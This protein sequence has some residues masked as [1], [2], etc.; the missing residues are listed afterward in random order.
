M[1]RFLTGLAGLALMA[2]P[3]APAVY[4]AAEVGKPAPDF[5]LEASDGKAHRL[6][7]HLGEFVVLEWY[8]KSCPFVKKH[9]GSGNMQKLQ[10]T[11]LHKGVTWFSIISSAPGKE[12]YLTRREAVKNRIDSKIRST[13]TLFDPEGVAGRAYGAEVTPH[14]FIIDPKGAVI[15]AGAIDSHNSP[16]PA[17]IPSST[18]YVAQAL[19]QALA[20]RPVTTP[21]TT[22]YGCSIKY[23]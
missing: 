13:A 18:N 19:D 23:K 15:Y 5:S 17:D 1:K 8:N 4:A 21:S 9:Y 3:A 11:Y 7:D 16:D 2:G 6:S 22:P 14:M 12:G 10:G 20:G